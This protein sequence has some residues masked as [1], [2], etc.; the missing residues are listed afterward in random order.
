LVIV[1]SEYHFTV[2]KDVVRVLYGHWF[3]EL[4]RI[5]PPVTRGP[6]CQ[7]KCVPVV[8]VLFAKIPCKLLR[9]LRPSPSSPP[10]APP[11][12]LPS[13]AALP[14][15]LLAP[16]SPIP[17]SAA[18]PQAS[19]G[20][21][22]CGLWHAVHGG[23]GGARGAVPFRHDEPHK[24]VQTR[25]APQAPPDEAPRF[26]TGDGERGGELR[27]RWVQVPFGVER[28]ATAAPECEVACSEHVG[29][30]EA[31][32]HVGP[33][34]STGSAVDEIDAAAVCAAVGEDDDGIDDLERCGSIP[35]Q[36]G[37]GRRVR[38]PTLTG[39]TR[40]RPERGATT[41]AGRGS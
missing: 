37:L 39:W 2:T 29:D 7:D 13:V 8:C 26:G 4:L 32:L 6:T 5:C 27:R 15:L 12:H 24:L 33:H 14:C 23:Q 10:T 25:R 38:P 31:E 11:L 21:S 1:H 35:L 16:P 19:A 9:V 28:A 41:A 36:G 34:E 30:G 3:L 22:C 20:S 18:L 17:L 40:A